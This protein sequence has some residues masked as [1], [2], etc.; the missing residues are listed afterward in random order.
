MAT[1]YDESNTLHDCPHCLGTGIGTADG[2]PCWYCK[3]SGIVDNRPA[4]DDF[5]DERRSRR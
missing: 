1:I 2:I 3:G 5:E 4:P